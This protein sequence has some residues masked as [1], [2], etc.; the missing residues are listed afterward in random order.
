MEQFDAHRR[1]LLTEDGATALSLVANNSTHGD[2]TSLAAMFRVAVNGIDVSA[3]P[4]AGRE[5]QTLPGSGL[6][7]LTK[8]RSLAA[9]R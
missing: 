9:F 5:V 1:R 2:S 4:P 3:K 8:R 6:G 7:V